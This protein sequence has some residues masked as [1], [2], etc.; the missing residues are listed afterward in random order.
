MK[1]QIITGDALTVLR[2]MEAE[3]VD[4]CVTSP[5]YYNL[6]DYG[7]EG[8][9]G[10]EET[11]EEYVEKMTEI[12][13]EVRRILR[14]DG[15]LWVVIGDSYATSS[16]PQAPRNT[17]NSQG[18]TPKR[19]PEGYKLKDLIGIPWMVAFALRADGWYL[20]QDII[21]NKTNC[22][23]ESVR[24]RCTRS[25]EYVF[26]FSKAR[27]YYYDAE[28]ISEPITGNSTER[29]LRE[30]KSGEHGTP[31]LPRF[32]GNKYV[33]DGDPVDRRK[34]GSTYIPKLRRNKRDVWSI[35]TGGF[36]GAH[37]AVFPPQLVRPI[38]LAGCRPG[39]TV[40]DPFVG[41]GTTA[42]VAIE[43]GRDYIGIEI[44]PAYVEMATERIASAKKP[45]T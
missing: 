30:L 5:P 9:L 31:H 29:Y 22:M 34:D 27:A 15:T 35:C 37:F 8:Q 28:A 32:G 21:W 13:R 24:D 40:L 38:I 14:K 3:S 12:F 1:N 44:N 18:H 45:N 36:K 23:P 42:A 17:R 33:T 11:P 20:R 41:S 19:V 26:M 39:G 2:T 4:M 6:R 7:I 25:H 16:G 43:E 10:H